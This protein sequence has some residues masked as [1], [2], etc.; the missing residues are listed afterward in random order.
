MNQKEHLG[1]SATNEGLPREGFRSSRSASLVAWGGMYLNK[2]WKILGITLVRRSLFVVAFVLGLILKRS[3]RSRLL[4]RAT[5]PAIL[6][7]LLAILMFE[8]NMPETILMD[9]LMSWD[10]VH[11]APKQPA[12]L[13]RHLPDYKHSFAGSTY[14]YAASQATGPQIPQSP[15]C[16]T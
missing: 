2:L 10:H 6:P 8:G 4:L 11:A 13:D 5:L 12:L 9:M 7:A 1:A 16:R 3:K 15:L 14:T